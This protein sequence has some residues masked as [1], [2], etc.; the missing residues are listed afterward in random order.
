MWRQNGPVIINYQW[1]Y[2]FADLN[3]FSF[4]KTG[5]FIKVQ[6]HTMALRTGYSPVVIGTVIIPKYRTYTDPQESCTVIDKCIVKTTP[7]VTIKN[8]TWAGWPG[9]Y[10]KY[11]IYS[12]FSKDNFVLNSL[13]CIAEFRFFTV[14]YLEAYAYA[15]IK[16]FDKVTSWP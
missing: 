15:T 13:L 3:L 1:F 9:E 12:T 16:A 8:I 6:I 10:F 5:G 2:V 11:H 4:P 14:S 7:N